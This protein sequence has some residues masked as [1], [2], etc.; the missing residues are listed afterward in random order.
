MG[1][2]PSPIFGAVTAS[3]L[4][5]GSTSVTGDLS[6]AGTALFG[7]TQFVSAAPILAISSAATA[8]DTTGA[9]GIAF[10]YGDGTNVLTGFIGYD[11]SSSTFVVLRDSVD[12]SGNHTKITGKIVADLI[13]TASYAQALIAGRTLSLTGDATA[14]LTF[15]GSANVSAALTLASTGVSGGSYGSSTLVPTF[16]VDGKGRLTA[17][18]TA[19]I[20]FPVTSVAGRTGDVTLSSADIS[21]ATAANTAS[22]IV[23]RDTTGSFSASTITASLIGNASTASSASKLTTAR[24]ITASGDLSWTVNFDGSAAATAAAT[25]AS[26]GVPAGSYGST[27][28]VGVFTVDAKGRLTA[29]SNSAIAFPVTSVFGRTGAVTLSSSD[30][31]SALGFTPLNSQGPSTLTGN[32]TVTGALT[33]QGA[34]TLAGLT[35]TTSNTLALGS[36]AASTNDGQD[37]GIAFGYGNGSSVLTGFMG[38]DISAGQF[39]LLT[40]ATASSGAYSGTT[41]T[42][43]AN[44][45]GNA[46]TATKLAAART[47]SLTG[48]ATGSMSFNGGTNA[49]AAVTLASTG[50][51][52]GSYGSTTSVSTFTVDAKGRLTAAGTAAIAFPVTSVFGRSGAITL[53]SSD[54][55]TALGYTPVNPGAAVTLAS[56][57]TISGNLIINGTTT[58][59]HST[60][61]TADDPV[62]VLGSNSSATNDGKARGLEFQYGDGTSVQTG[63]LG[64]DTAA[65]TF[66]LLTATTDNSG[67]VTGTTGTLV[68]NLTGN[69]S[70][71]TTLATARTISVTGDATGSASFNG[72]ANAAIALTLANSGVTSGSYGSATSVPVLTLDAKGR[73]TAAS[74]SAISFPVTTVAGK[75]GAVTLASADIGDAASANTASVLVKRDANGNFSAGVITAT[76]AGNAS[77]ASSLATVRTLSLTGDAA[78]SLSFDGTSNVS[79]ALT[80]ANTSVTAGSYGSG[81]AVTTFTVDAKGRLTAAGTTAIAFPVTS[82]F[83]RTGAVSLTS[84]D[85]TGALGYTPV[86]PGAAT[87]FINDVT[88]SGNLTVTGTTALNSSQLTVADPVITVGSGSTGTNDG[89]GRGIAFQ[90][91]NGSAVLGG[92]FG[93]DTAAGQYVALTNTSNT[94]EVITGTT[95]TIAANLAGNASTATKLASAQT[96]SFTGDATGSLS[97]DGSAGASTALTLAATGVSAGSYGGATAIPVLTIDAKGRITS[98]STATISA[99]G[100][101]SVAGRSGDVTLTSADISD[102]ASANTASTLV[103]RDANG[104]FSAGTITAALSGNASSATKLATAQTIS[105]TGDATGSASFDGSANAAIALTLASTAV[106]A[107]SYGSSTVVPTFT[108]DAKGRLT[109][110]S[111]AAI[112][113]PVTSVFGR[114]GAVTLGS[115]D[116][117]GALGYSPVNPGAAVSLSSTLSVAGNVTTADPVITLGSATTATN[118]GKNRGFEFKYGNGS[119]ILSGF[120][121]FN[122]TSGQFVALTNTT[123]NAEV[124]TGTTATIVA[125]LTGNAGTA[126]KLATARTLSLTGDATGSM[127]FDGSANASAALTLAAS[128]VTA[129]SYGS[130]TTVPAITV[131]AKGRITAASSTAITFPVTSVFG[132]TGAVTLASADVTGALGYTPANPGVA[133]TFS[134]DLVVSGNLTVNG[135][136]TTL[137]STNIT[138]DDPII[139]LAQNATSTNDGK[140]RG[141]EFNYG[142]GNSVRMGFIGFDTAAGQFVFFTNATDTSSVLSGTVGT[143]AANL[144]GNASTASKLATAH[145]ISLTGDATGSLSFDGSADA[146][147]SLTLAT[148]GVSAGSYGSSTAVAAITVDAKGRVTAASSTAIAFPVTS[149]AGRTGAVTLASADIGDAVSANTASVLVKRDASGNFSAGTITAALSGNASTATKLATART[150]STTGDATGSASFDGS[151]NAAIALTLASTAVTAGSYGSSTSVSTFTVDGK[152]RL[153]AAGTSAIAFPVTSVAGKTGAVTLASAD[154]GDAASGNT[155]SVL[156]KRDANGNFSAGTIT[157]ALAGNA[158]TASALASARTIA[159]SGDVT[160]SASFDGSANVT[161]AM[162]L[163]SSGATAGTYG[164][165][166]AIPVIQVDA[167]GRITSVSTAAASSGAVTSVAGR[168]GAVT[169]STSDISGLASSYAPIANATMTGQNFIT[170]AAGTPGSGGSGNL[171]QRTEGGFYQYSA[172]TQALGYPENSNGW[173]H[174]ISSTHTNPNLYYAMQMAGGFF[175]NTNF[176]VRK[177]NNSGSAPW[178]KLWHSGNLAAPSF[179][180]RLI[181]GAFNINQRGIS[182]SSTTYNSGTYTLDRW[183]AGSNGVTMSFTINASNSNT[184]NIT[185]GTLLQIIEGQRYLNEGGSYVLSWTGSATARVYQGSAPG[186]SGSPLV[187]NLQAGSNAIVEFTGGTISNAQLEPG[188]SPSTYEWRDDE[189]YRCQRYYLTGTM[190]GPIGVGSSFAYCGGMVT[191]PQPM[192]RVPDIITTD[193]VGNQYYLDGGGT[194]HMYISTGS[195]NNRQTVGGGVA[196]YQDHIML[197][198]V[199]G[200]QDLN[201]WRFYYYCSAEM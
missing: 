32:L 195:G 105:A 125:N 9:R 48:D 72:S 107:G 30:V 135:T 140:A 99:G 95:A 127:S 81:T 84:S 2:L 179:R 141:I 131:D 80:L 58:T 63:F 53:S 33:I 104:N 177:T 185:N 74:S 148:S 43:A 122:T 169:L 116:V 106:T 28:S 39:V 129:S 87:T 123:N 194:P 44:L 175:D 66:K 36:A 178:N 121:G 61:I 158:S 161:I 198:A 130:A 27:T 193:L 120:L 41:A 93:Y 136:T 49:S 6:V 149:V 18:G 91:G 160:G 189:L 47:L 86:N 3:S 25:L 103:L 29:A 190:H 142:D 68:A 114:T 113:F 155:A 111:T 52:S 77:T 151:A 78:A 89:K 60:S 1:N 45:A 128:G 147:A 79:S 186:F 22:T 162:T 200:A 24:A 187:V 201:W 64:F 26:T 112:A 8:T 19:A 16:T 75:T 115:S 98:V 138:L 85:V 57:L 35:G 119:A 13:G 144:S 17:A 134:S 88:V 182:T 165:A 166:T 92:F 174:V 7:G 14:A 38:Y 109:A 82:V 15:D 108:V 42:L 83:G 101:T 12:G 171:T 154:I 34:T 97:F 67:V 71:A 132:R 137:H 100:V 76:L 167:K 133:T 10:N 37:R 164:S 23:T 173:C 56:D 157:A 199:L 31:T 90:Y 51:S 145:A 192:Y 126:T 181:N 172:A 46:T 191:F 184:V 118:D 94:S 196:G 124:I 168:T 146:S 69:A 143:L 96:L 65:G 176:Y 21:D 156:V 180:N 59:V 117:T 50:V 153:T 54:V 170:L 159:H 4:N 70:T 11:P 55:T 110:A 102:A 5:V 20:A 183:K 152:G 73:V 150:I 197:D 188:T 40:S 163:A 139:V 62:M